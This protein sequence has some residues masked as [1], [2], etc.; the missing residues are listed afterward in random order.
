MVEREEGK[1]VGVTPT[2]EQLR[3]VELRAEG[4]SYDKIAKELHRSKQT[5]INW[6]QRL[7]TEIHNYTNTRI[8][9]AKEQYKLLQQH[10]LEY[11]G[12]ALGKL[13][14][15]VE[16]R[17][18]KDLSTDRLLSLLLK[19]ETELSREAAPS[20]FKPNTRMTSFW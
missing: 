10:R 20:E 6:S 3:F 5:L 19:Y 16:N 11:L 8:E 4:L 7:E 14:E 18:L 17:D 15:E 12:K 9:A 13:R 1:S 2:E